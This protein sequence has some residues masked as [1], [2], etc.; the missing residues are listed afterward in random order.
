[1][2]DVQLAAGEAV[3]ASQVT[4][5]GADL[6]AEGV[7]RHCRWEGKVVG[8]VAGETGTGAARTLVPQDATDLVTQA[9]LAGDADSRRNGVS[10]PRHQ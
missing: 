10:V 8:A 1:M 4:A 9:F 2:T 7:V 5:G 6:G 3:L